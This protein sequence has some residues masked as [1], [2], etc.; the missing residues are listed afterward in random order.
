[1]HKPSGRKRKSLRR[2]KRNRTISFWGRRSCEHPVVSVIIPAMNEQKTIRDVIREAWQVHES[3]EVIVVANGCND[4]TAEIALAMGAQVLQFD[5]PL[6]H[7]VGRTIGAK[8]S[9]GEVLLFVDADMRIKS[10]YLRPFV[11]AVLKGTDVALNSYRGP[12][13]R[14][15]VHP[16]ILA[17]HTLNTML[18]RSD[19]LGASLTAVPHAMSRRAADIIGISNLSIPPLAQ[20]IAIHSNLIVSAVHHVPVGRLNRRRGK[21]SGQDLLQQ[22]VIDDHLQALNWYLSHTDPRGGH[23]DLGRK[24]EW[25]GR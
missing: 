17:K 8:A 16:V 25:A 15:Q 9:K 2:R 21:S 24:R 23:N 14:R 18:K 7:D 3:T 19:L 20:A 1:M 11:N 22:V 4:R 10:H 12:V 13:Q 6:G 5:Q